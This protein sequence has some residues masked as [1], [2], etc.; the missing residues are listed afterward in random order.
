MGLMFGS[1]VPTIVFVIW[2][3]GALGLGNGPAREQSHGLLWLVLFLSVMV[4]LMIAGYAL[5][6][7]LNAAV[8]RVHYGWSGTKIRE[9]FLESKIPEEWREPDTQGAQPNGAAP[10]KRASWA[11]TRQEGFAHYVV[12]RGVCGWGLAMFTGMALMPVL[13]HR[14][15]ASLPALALQAAI[16]LVAGLAFGIGTWSWN[17]FLFKRQTRTRSVE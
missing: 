7:M 13:L 5:G 14:R 4:T 12:V 3:S 17:E 6:W 1:F 10:R 16:W 8:A 2:L 11:T 15:P 9:V